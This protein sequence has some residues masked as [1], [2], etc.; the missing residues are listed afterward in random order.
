MLY[1]K[2]KRILN[3]KAYGWKADGDANPMLPLGFNGYEPRG[4]GTSRL[5]K[6]SKPIKEEYEIWVKKKGV[7]AVLSGTAP[8]PKK[9]YEINSDESIKYIDQWV[10]NDC[11]EPL[12]IKL[13][14][15]TLLNE[16]EKDKDVFLILGAKYIVSERVIEILN[17]LCPN[18]FETYDVKIVNAY[19]N[20]KYYRINLLR[21]IYEEDLN[22]NGLPDDFIIGHL[23]IKPTHKL[24]EDKVETIFSERL[25]Q[26]FIQ[27]NITGLQNWK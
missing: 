1:K 7:Q 17:K 4:K 22:E 26:E 2:L 15:S 20:K 27:N 16:V 24:L 13:D 18:D 6:G 10:K 12:E 25:S 8:K 23:R 3:G 9:D 14:E 5:F 19:T 11:K 21:S